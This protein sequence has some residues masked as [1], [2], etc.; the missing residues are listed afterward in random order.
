[1]IDLDKWQEIYFS[2]KQHKLR[3]S[4][5][6]FG[7]FWGIFMLVTLLG[8]GNGLKN[9]VL[10]NFGGQTNTIYLWSGSPTQIPYQGLQRGRR[11]NFTDEDVVLIRQQIP[12]VDILT[13]NN[14]L[15][16]WDGAQYVVR[17][18]KHGAFPTKGAHAVTARLKSYNMQAGRFLNEADEAEKRKVAVI[19]TRVQETLFAEG[20]N[21]IGKS[22]EIRGIYFVVVGVFVGPTM[23]DNAQE[24]AE[25]VL[26]P[27]ATLRYTFNQL[28][29]IG[30][31]TLTPKAGFSA[32]DL[33]KKVKDLLLERHHIHPD[34]VGTIGSFNLQKEY[35]KVMGLFSGIRIF[36]W[37]VAAGTIIA[38]VVGV[39]NIML[40]VVKERTKE[41]GVRK[42]LGATSKS[43][44][45]MIVQE[46]V[47]I[48]AV[49]GYS[50]LV[51]GVLLLETVNRVLGQQGVG[52]FAKPEVDFSTALIAMLLL[53]VAG[54]L[55]AMLP[56]YKA[57]K[58]D[59]IVALQ[60]E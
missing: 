10:L 5:T 12:E 39:G 2:L 60:D 13:G 21:P 46:A 19:G 52:M 53:V 36:S 43:I 31:L 27:N 33:E 57:A 59:P 11:I 55:A 6:A 41:I 56:A 26:V 35:E 42:A 8:A 37:V 54:V 29:W 49:A 1:M 38:G 9:G 45:L 51:V 47:V 15:A 44:V 14:D 16:A 3:T 50:G 30:H 40:I 22:V 25:K 28:G 23:G 32:I 48:T 34:D 7:V 20:E 24:E 18:E 4:L 58:V 17:G